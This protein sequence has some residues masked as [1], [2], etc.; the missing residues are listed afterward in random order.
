MTPALLEGARQVMRLI[1]PSRRVDSGLDSGW[2]I[3]YSFG[4]DFRM[5]FFLCHPATDNLGV[6]TPPGGTRLRFESG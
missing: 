1:G 2:A 5:V 3:R 4:S 6:L